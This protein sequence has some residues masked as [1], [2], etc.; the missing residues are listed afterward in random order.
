MSAKNY[1][2]PG[3]FGRLIHRDVKADNT[4][5]VLA[6]CDGTHTLEDIVRKTKLPLEETI[7]QVEILEKEGY[8][9]PVTLWNRIVFLRER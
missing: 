4:D 5:K 8:I 2:V 7:K 1:H 9:V 3:M 6:L